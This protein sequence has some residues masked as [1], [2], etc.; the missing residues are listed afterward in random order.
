[1]APVTADGPEA[2][3]Q[4]H[5]Q[6]GSRQVP[7]QTESQTSTGHTKGSCCIFLDRLFNFL[8]RC[9]QGPKTELC[10]PTQ[11]LSYEPGCDEESGGQ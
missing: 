2:S 4:T 10:H 5:H 9:D 1:M 3:P 7:L 8:L 11:I 6:A